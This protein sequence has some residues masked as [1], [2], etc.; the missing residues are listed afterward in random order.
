MTTSYWL[1]HTPRLKYNHGLSK[2]SMRTMYLV[3]HT[4]LLLLLDLLHRLP[5]APHHFSL[6]LPPLSTPLLRPPP[7]P[8]L[9]PSF[10]LLPSAPPPLHLRLTS[11]SPLPHLRSLYCS[12]SAPPPPHVRFT[13]ASP[14]PHLRFT[15]ASPPPHLRPT[16]TAE[17]RRGSPLLQ[18]VT[19]PARHHYSQHATTTPARHHYSPPPLLPAR[20]HCS[21]DF[22]VFKVVPQHATTTPAR[23]PYSV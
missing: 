19:T 1:W 5:A 7:V 3:P 13:S 20:H 21:H 22:M 12:T 2:E 9:L 8:P 6:L 10:P 14:P 17:W 4:F 11:A 23:H 18:H 15:S 16:S